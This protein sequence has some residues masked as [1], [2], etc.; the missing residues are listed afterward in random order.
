[1]IKIV[2]I[3][4]EENLKEADIK[5]SELQEPIFAKI[6]SHESDENSQNAYSESI[7]L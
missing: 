3:P 4:E 1:M 6:N 2:T 7:I 5:E